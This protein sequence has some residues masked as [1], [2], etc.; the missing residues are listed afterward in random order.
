[1]SLLAQSLLLASLIVSTALTAL[2][3]SS[4]REGRPNVLFIMADDLNCDLGCYGNEFVRTPGIDRLA[5]RAA[6]FERAYC[7]YPVCNP[8]RVS[9]L[10]G[11]RPHA[12]RV[13]DNTTQ[14]RAALSNVV[15]LPEWFRRHGYRT[16]KLGKIFHTGDE[17][18]D[19]R[20]WD[21]DERETREAKNP[22]AD[23]I[24]RRVGAKES[25]IVIRGPDELGWDGK[26]ARRGVEWLDKLSA[27]DEPFFLAVGFRRPHT[28]YLAPVTY[29]DL[30]PTNRV[31]PLVEPAGHVGKIPPIAL[32]YNAGFDR[33]PESERAATAAAYWASLSY[34]DAQVGM[35]LEAL[36]RLALWDDTIV[37][38]VSDHGYHLGEHGG[39]WHKMSLFE[40]SARVPLLIATPG[41]GAS[42]IAG[43]A[44]LVDLYPTLIE[45]CELPKQ[46][47]LAGESLAR[48]LDDPAA[49]GK[50]FA[51]TVVSRAG[52]GPN[53]LDADRLSW[54][55]RTPRWRYT[56]WHDGS[57]ELYDHDA[58]PGE[59]TN[60]AGDPA[61]AETLREL[62]EAIAHAAGK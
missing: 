18:E 61:H 17:F 16:V 20:S 45:L 19:P 31:P 8:S 60:L 24:L 22:P 28:P 15:C 6:R 5:A 46:E 48:L 62:A 29:F 1:M 13:V 53:H 57:R 41:R 55:V 51:I 33:L 39:L 34:M 27:A 56:Q 25:G 38:F 11:L 43:L 7:Q 42:Q 47:N 49:T 36:D 54:S 9:L 14:L 35:L 40:P 2:P 3:A 50:P 58:D 37:V 30:Y 26:L 12:T 52:T 59:F 21:V 32:T 44:E 23:Q 4:A 10:S